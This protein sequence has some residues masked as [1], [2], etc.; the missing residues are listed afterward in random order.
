MSSV[1]YLLLCII[2]ISAV[3]GLW[4]GLVR[5]M[6][7]VMV[8]VAA[9]WVAYI[10]TYTVAGYLHNWISD[11]G[12]RLVA[13]F[14]LIFVVVY[15]IGFVLSRLLTKLV[16]AVGMTAT[17]RIAGS[18]F[19]VVRGV[20][21]VSVLVLLVDMT[22]MVQESAWQQSYMVGVFDNMLHWVQQQ[23]PVSAGDFSQALKFGQAEN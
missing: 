22:P 8:W 4:R 18:G 6:M 9:F 2:A 12:L 10:E 20:V 14:L 15:L 13:A 16:E 5:E 1:D 21:L 17:D 11:R 19:G 23:Y 7:S 3:I